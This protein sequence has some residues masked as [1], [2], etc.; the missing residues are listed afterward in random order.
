MSTES[1]TKKLL[2]YRQ[3]LE[4]RIQE[5]NNE[6]QDLKKALE[7]IDQHIVT[8]GFKTPTIV[9]TRKEVDKTEQVEGQ[10]GTSITAKDGTVLGRMYTDEENLSFKPRENFS[11]TTDLPPFNSFL[12]DRVF[13]NMKT[14]DEERASRG[15]LDPNMILE[16][17]V[18][19]EGTVIKEIQIKNYGEERRLRE[20]NSSLRW[21]FD[22]MFEKINEP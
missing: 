4:N 18:E 22:K 20:I 10:K 16:Y 5:L 9:R 14:T 7:V 15:E 1:E 2:H 12:I 19:T 3:F 13:A 21:T 11:F 17:N 8:Q 6:I